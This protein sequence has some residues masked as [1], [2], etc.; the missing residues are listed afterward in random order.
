MSEGV[1]P[2][3]DGAILF[4]TEANRFAGAGRSVV[5]GSTAIDTATSG[6]AFVTLGSVVIGAARS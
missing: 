4:S 3:A 1:F 6:T 2:K 5:I